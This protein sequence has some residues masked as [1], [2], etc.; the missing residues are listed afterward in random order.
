MRVKQTTT[1]A[2][3]RCDTKREEGPSH[4]GGLC[5]GKGSRPLRHPQPRQREQ[6]GRQL[7]SPSQVPDE[8]GQ[9]TIAE[10]ANSKET[11]GPPRRGGRGSCAY[12][13][14]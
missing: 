3:C 8:Q 2:R 11:S 4:P 7:C 14:Y 6:E 9:N 1:W 13:A 5:A 12:L 10:G